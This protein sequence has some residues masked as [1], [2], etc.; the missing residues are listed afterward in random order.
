MCTLRPLVVEPTSGVVSVRIA[1]FHLPNANNMGGDFQHVLRAEPKSYQ[2]APLQ[3]RNYV[4]DPIV[5][6]DVFLK[7]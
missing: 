7:A 1:L 5:T 3:L 2:P 6:D 4:L